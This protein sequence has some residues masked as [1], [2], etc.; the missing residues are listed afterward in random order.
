MKHKKYDY[1]TIFLVLLENKTIF[2]IF[3]T[4]CMSHLFSAV[5]FVNGVLPSIHA[6]WVFIPEGTGIL[7]L[8]RKFFIWL[9]NRHLEYIEEIEK[10]INK[11]A[12][13]G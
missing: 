12:L 1:G 9:V 4:L 7:I 5:L 2:L 6:W 11:K 10:K 8:L 3:A 13:T